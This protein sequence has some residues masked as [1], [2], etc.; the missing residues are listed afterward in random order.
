MAQPT[1]QDVLDLAQQLSPADRSRLLQEVV[2]LPPAVPP[3]SQYGVLAHVGPAP[4]MED[5]DAVR[6]ELSADFDL[7]IE[8]T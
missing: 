3:R 8:D 1:L 7:G 2:Q 4:S 5:F 6:R